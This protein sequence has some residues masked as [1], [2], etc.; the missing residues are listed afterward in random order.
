MSVRFYY[1]R[2]PIKDLQETWRWASSHRRTRI[3]NGRRTGWHSGTGLLQESRI[4]TVDQS[5]FTGFGFLRPN[6]LCA[7]DPIIEQW[8]S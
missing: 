2:M 3:H 4:V 8:I 7:V 6:Q 5:S 1:G